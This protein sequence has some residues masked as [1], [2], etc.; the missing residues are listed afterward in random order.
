M[1]CDCENGR[2]FAKCICLIG[3]LKC[4]NFEACST[5]YAWKYTK[6]ILGGIE[7]R[8]IIASIVW[9]LSYYCVRRESDM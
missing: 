9:V 3:A 8:F 1:L 2:G 4:E 6:I 5:L 7:N